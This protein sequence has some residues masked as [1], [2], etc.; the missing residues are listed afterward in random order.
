MFRPV[1]TVLLGLVFSVSVFANEKVTEVKVN[2]F[3]V[4]LVDLEKGNQFGY[5]FAVPYG[6]ADDEPK[7]FGRAHF[8]EHMFAR[9][10]K[11]FPGHET[12]IKAISGFGYERNAATGFDFT[13]YYGKGHEK[14]AIEAMT[15]HMASLEEPDLEASSMTREK[16][17]VKNEIIVSAPSRPTRAIYTLPFMVLPQEGHGLRGQWTGTDQTLDPMSADDL[18]ELHNRIYHAA[19]VKIAIF[20]NFKNGTLSREKIVEELGHILPKAEAKQAYV[21]TSYTPMFTQA[22]TLEILNPNQRMGALLLQLPADAD[23]EGVN[24][25]LSTLTGNDRHGLLDIARRK[26]GW[27]TSLGGETFRT[28]SQEVVYVQFSLTD[29][30]YQNRERFVNWLLES[31]KVGQTQKF[32]EAVL[33]Q[34]RQVVKEGFATVKDDLDALIHNFPQWMTKKHTVKKVFLDW[35]KTAAVYNADRIMAAAKNIQLEN[36]SVVLMGPE[37]KNANLKDSFH[38]LQYGISPWQDRPSQLEVLDISR[39]E[40]P[41]I[42]LADVK[43]QGERIIV[44]GW[45]TVPGLTVLHTNNANWNDRT[46]EVNLEF[47][48]MTALEQLSLEALIYSVRQELSPEIMTLKSKGIEVSV[49]LDSKELTLNVKS[50]RGDEVATLAWLLQQI[51]SFKMTEEQ[52]KQFRDRATLSLQSV[53]EGF[54]AAAAI[55]VARQLFSPYK[56][57]PLLK[58]QQLANLSLQSVQDVMQSK[59]MKTYKN[60]A[61]GGAY[62]QNEMDYLLAATADFS[63]LNFVNPPAENLPQYQVS[64]HV[65]YTEGWEKV[66]QTSLG[67]IGILKG[68]ERDNVREKAAMAIVAEL[69]R[70]QV[71]LRNRPL[72]YMQGAARLTF[73]RRN[74]HFVFYGHVGTS[75]KLPQLLGVWDEEVVR[76][77][78][79]EVTVEDIEK[80]RKG[81]ISQLSKEANSSNEGLDVLT[82]SLSMSGDPFFTTKMLA[83]LET[84]TSEEVYAVAAK[85]LQLGRPQ[86]LITKGYGASPTCEDMLASRAEVKK[87]LGSQ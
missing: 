20:A 7:M 45:E 54:A 71:F 69:M 48:P 68:P 25:F 30:G 11:K 19:N 59:L 27:I 85:Y 18:R 80:V 57:S 12:L 40:V 13:M 10:S 37:A 46:F 24:A 17:T 22:Q 76:F 34:H 51:K 1:L 72:G 78:K 67:V 70:E 64:Q 14:H 50:R 43:G 39:M 6:S 3:T 86:M 42:Q 87:R 36:P 79:R 81:Q 29:E 55:E 83:A 77:V 9:G 31:I 8:F 16:A 63:P 84:M 23:V 53:E 61:V 28:G 47:A 5:T 58:R 41:K 60:L 65:Q 62:Y 15:M 56:A 82:G 26:L 2:G 35:E 74:E 73:P 38:N 66:D 44:E 49:G 4:Y 75:D 52:L 21:P 32:P 33:E